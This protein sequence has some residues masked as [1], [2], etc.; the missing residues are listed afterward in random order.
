MP[1]GAVG[2]PARIATAF[3]GGAVGP[4]PRSVEIDLR[5]RHGQ[6]LGAIPALSMTRGGTY[7]RLRAKIPPAPL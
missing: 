6:N 3:G 2:P 1:S 5:W 4:A 7:V